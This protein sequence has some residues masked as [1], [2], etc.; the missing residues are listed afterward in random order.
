MCVCRCG[1]TLKRDQCS[2]EASDAP[3]PQQRL[4]SASSLL[5]DFPAEVAPDAPSAIARLFM[6]LMTKLLCVYILFRPTRIPNFE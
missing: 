3:D 5:S 6:V 4:R 2:T 1:Y